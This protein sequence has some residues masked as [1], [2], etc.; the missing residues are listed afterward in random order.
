M[1]KVSV[2]I[3]VYGVEKYIERCAHTLFQQTL[4]D[5][6]Y[7]FIDDCT[8]DNSIAVL[9]RVIAEYPNRSEQVII[10]RMEKN[11]GQAKVREWGMKNASGEYVIH[12]D[13]DDWIDLNMYEDMYKLATD[14]GADI[15]YCDYIIEGG[16]N[17]KKRFYR[18]VN[19]LSKDELMKRLL[20]TSSLNSLWSA[21]VKK[22]LIGRISFPK[23]NQSEDKTMLIQLGWYAGKVVGIDKAFYHYVDNPTS[24]TNAVSPEKIDSRAQQIFDNVD[25]ILS[26]FEK[27]NII[28]RYKKFLCAYF[29]NAKAIYFVLLSHPKYYSKWKLKYRDFTKYYLFDPYIHWKVKIATLLKL[30]KSFKTLLLNEN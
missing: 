30:C 25:L 15:V 11:S 9:K 16:P 6:E 13:S 8:P 4:D 18:Q 12:C 22:T 24:I 17:D 21:L 3:P 14:A 28:N 27:E 7:L 26:F 1:A 2:I 10:H 29:F 20:T 23:G 19:G 5:I